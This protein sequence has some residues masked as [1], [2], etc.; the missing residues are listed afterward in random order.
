MLIQM[1]QSWFN[2][3]IIHLSSV[4]LNTCVHRRY[5]RK[6]HVTFT[7]FMLGSLHW[8]PLSE[9][10]LFKIVH[11]HPSSISPNMQSS[12]FIFLCQ[13]CAVCLLTHFIIIYCTR[14]LI[15]IK[16]LLFFIIGKSPH[17]I[18]IIFKDFFNI[19]NTKRQ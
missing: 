14:S 13:S 4:Y 19:F 5:I 17:F 7:R 6:F 11:Q 10:E 18:G 9:F 16:S 12:D 2:F 3:S 15:S 1:Y 8:R